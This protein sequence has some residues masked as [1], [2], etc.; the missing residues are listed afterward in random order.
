MK[1]D[2]KDGVKYIEYSFEDWNN[3]S[4]SNLKIGEEM[5]IVIHTNGEKERIC[6]YLP[7]EEH[8]K[9]E[10]R[11]KELFEER[12][13]EYLKRLSE[14]FNKRFNDSRDKKTLLNRE[15]ELYENLI[16]A[17]K[18]PIPALFNLEPHK[19]PIEGIQFNA[20][21]I[22]SIRKAY[23]E[24]IINGNISYD[25]VSCNS[26]SPYMLNPSHE[27]GSVIAESVYKYIQ[28]LKNDEN[29][30]KISVFDE[31]ILSDIHKE[32]N[33]GG[34][35]K[36]L[37]KVEF[38]ESFQGKGN[39][40]NL[41][42]RKQADFCYIIGLIEDKRNDS[43]CLNFAKWVENTFGIKQNSYKKQKKE[44]ESNSKKRIEIKSKINSLMK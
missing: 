42:E 30:K 11:K 27:S 41:M 10:Q 38:I 31:D 7:N 13:S 2:T 21:G 3:G 34:I 37:D 23:N 36:P 24:R 6:F 4:F 43:S 8:E 1:E 26:F 25:F 16:C 14:G 22:N 5:K 15:I 32:F 35:W 28:W 33:K 39:K 19:S 29:A 18:M 12:V 20:N 44:Y 40:I 17:E 9:I